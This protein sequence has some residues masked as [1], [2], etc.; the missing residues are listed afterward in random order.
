MAGS[1]R[2][3]RTSCEIAMSGRTLKP[4]IQTLRITIPDND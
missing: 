1:T 2:T 4:Q 3:A